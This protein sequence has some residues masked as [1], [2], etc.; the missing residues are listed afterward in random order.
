MGALMRAYDWEA[1]PL[2][3]PEQWPQS[4]KANIRLLLNSEFPMFIWWSQG[5]YAFHND[6]YLPALGQK[7]PAALGASARTIWA[8]IWE[9]IGG[10]AENI[11]AGGES[12][13]T[14][15][16]QLY[17]DRNGFL[18]ETYWTFSYSPAFDDDGQVAGVFCACS[19]QTS[20]M[21]GQRRL[22]TLTAL[23]GTLSQLHTLEQVGQTSCA[24]LAQNQNDI[25]FSQLYLVNRSQSQAVLLGESGQA[26][27]P[28]PPVISLQGP[29]GSQEWP[30]EEVR[31]S[32][33]S[34][35]VETGR[36]PGERS[37]PE[38]AVVLPIVRSGHEQVLGFL[39]LG[40]SPS[41]GYDTDYL[42][43]HELVAGQIATAIASVQAREEAARRQAELSNLFQQAPVAI[44]I[45]TGPNFVIDLANPAICEI[46]GKSQQEVLGKPVLE[47]LPEIKGQGIKELLEGVVQTGIPYV[48]NELPLQFMRNG[49][50]E[51][52]Y[53]SF[54]YQPLRSAQ[55]HVTGV[56]AVAVEINEQVEARLQ[57][58]AKNKELLAI[59]ADLDNFVYSASHDL[60]APISNIEGLVQTLVEHLP[61]E[62]QQ[63]EVVQRVLRLMHAS[64]SRFKRAV[65]DLTEV[66]K[67][68]REA[69]ED[70][71]FI[72]LAEV[73][74][75]VEL[76]FENMINA[77]GARLQTQFAPDS[78]VRFS[79]KNVRS[80]VYNLVSNALKYR[81]PHRMPLVEITTQEV[82][83]YLVLSVSDNG[84]GINASDQDKI[85]TMFKRLHDH[86]EGTGIGLY[87]VKRIVENA[88]GHIELESEKD[89]GTT[90]RVFFR[91]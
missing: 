88:G 55:G 2:G 56:I 47:A 43:F 42:N 87:I 26:F 74:A 10:I 32:R 18:E 33:K 48:N 60:K 46:W 71:T 84:L 62:V 22:S 24:L 53:L 40:I 81:S 66:A 83:G 49:A 27:S 37:L 59:N 30:F 85:F 11:L 14:E 80:V 9:D 1:H 28:A 78:T 41:L 36:Q 67:V 34:L 72:D 68:Q 69:G 45:A 35:L 64:V 75:D 90:F 82:P 4:L 89:Q 73:V 38:R 8:E 6:A 29:E 7:H 61:K 50:M 12:F 17:L 79:A 70:V 77:T 23:A 16:L 25:P 86:V 15:G 19:E 76:D 52:V 39:V 5:L 13:Y 20:T 63:Q 91:R 3:S 65:S 51:T 21:L 54:V 57:I 31:R 44:A 58:E